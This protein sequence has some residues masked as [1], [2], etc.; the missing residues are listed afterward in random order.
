MSMSAS[1]PGSG[2]S[3]ML[4]AKLKLSME[5][6]KFG[7]VP[8]MPPNWLIF[9]VAETPQST[10][11]VPCAAC[12]LLI[13]PPS[14]SHAAKAT[15]AVVVEPL[16]AP[17]SY[18]FQNPPSPVVALPLYQVVM[19]TDDGSKL[20]SESFKPGAARSCTSKPAPS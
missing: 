10:P 3:K 11:M 17:S 8:L 12:K 6:G 16:T 15:V 20:A 14:L 4:Y 9:P 2:V 1:V 18:E 13:V 5:V 7:A 19:G